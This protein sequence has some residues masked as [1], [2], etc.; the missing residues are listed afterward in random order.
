VDR[1]LLRRTRDPA[2]LGSV[3]LWGRVVE[4]TLGYRAEFG[5][6]QRVALICPLC[7]WRWGAERAGAPLVA[8]RH[9]GGRIVPLCGPHLELCRR[10]G[11][12]ARRLLE[13]G[14]VER[15]LLDAY[16]VDLLPIARGVP[17]ADATTSR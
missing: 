5:Y 8:V 15:A 2:A 17:R 10:Y 13:V 9:R 12:P 11:Y 6:P 3:A 14:L 4:H 7:F 1:D 16:A